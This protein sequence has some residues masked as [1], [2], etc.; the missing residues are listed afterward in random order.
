MVMELEFSDFHIYYAAG[1][2]GVKAKYEI[3]SGKS[4]SGEKLWELMSA[5]DKDKGPGRIIRSKAADGSLTVVFN[6][7][8]TS[9]YYTAKAGRQKFVNICLRI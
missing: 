3:Y 9:S 1:S 7:N 8:T 4:V 5:D 6:A 2:Y